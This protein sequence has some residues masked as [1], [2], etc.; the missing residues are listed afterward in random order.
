MWQI[1]CDVD[2][3]KKSGECQMK[4]KIHIKFHW[5]YFWLWSIPNLLL[6]TLY[7]ILPLILYLAD[8][9]WSIVIAISFL[10]FITFYGLFID[11][12]VP[13]IQN[14]F[15]IIS[16]NQFFI[17]RKKIYFIKNAIGH[18][19]NLSDIIDVSEPN[20]PLKT[21]S[22]KS[23]VDI[24]PKE[25]QIRFRN[26]VSVSIPRCVFSYERIVAFLKRI[27]ARNFKSI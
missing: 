13:H 20:V 15:A 19:A 14:C 2:C 23:L 26:G 11:F 25:C 18:V 7:L 8:F 1:P 6:F 10:I 17:T 9:D 16:T 21:R 3:I 22:V 27:Q 5:P 24:F 4:T 12:I